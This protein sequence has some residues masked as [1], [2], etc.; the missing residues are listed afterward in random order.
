MARSFRFLRE[1]MSPEAR[2]AAKQK[3]QAMLRELPLQEPWQRQKPSQNQ[4]SGRLQSKPSIIF[5]IERRTGRRII[6][7]KTMRNELEMSTKFLH[8]RVYRSKSL[9]Y[10][11]GRRSPLKF[12]TQKKQE[13]PARL[14]HGTLPDASIYETKPLS[15]YLS[16]AKETARV[17]KRSAD[18]I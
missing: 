15:S 18:T 8:S 4:L 10:R 17:N 3:T 1:R 7:Y 14:W 16:I 11:H 13:L 6:L 12:S 9:K 2:E 5:E